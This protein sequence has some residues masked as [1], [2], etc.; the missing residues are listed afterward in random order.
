MCVCVYISVWCV[1]VHTYTH[2]HIHIQVCG[3]CVCMYVL[4]PGSSVGKELSC[5]AGDTGDMGSIPGWERSTREGNGNPLQHSGLENPMD[6]GA[7][8][9][10][11][12]GVSKSR[13]QSKEFIMHAGT[14]THT[15][16]Q[17]CIFYSMFK[18]TDLTLSSFSFHVGVPDQILEN[19]SYRQP[20]SKIFSGF[21]AKQSLSQPFDLDLIA[22]GR[23]IIS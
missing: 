4:F 18:T 20:D 6:R 3:V 21:H 9:A 12:P 16:T 1:C 2:I 7:W 10:T 17:T 22:W 13:T 19:F 11:V 8:R 23:Q 14:H 5:N 15:N